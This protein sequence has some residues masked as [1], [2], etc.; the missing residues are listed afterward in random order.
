MSNSWTEQE[1][2]TLVTARS[3]GLTFSEISARFL[4]HRSENSLSNR[5]NALYG[6]E[7][8]AKPYC[9]LSTPE[10]AAIG[11]K[12]LLRAQIAAG[13]VFPKAMAAWIERHGP[14]Q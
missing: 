14:V 5:Y 13:Q 11:S 8:G 2:N 1:D 3:L 4:A 7:P 10:A 9:A 6:P 12:A